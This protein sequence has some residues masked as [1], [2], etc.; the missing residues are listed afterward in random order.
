MSSISQRSLDFVHLF[1]PSACQHAWKLAR[2]STEGEAESLLCHPST[3]CVASELFP[4]SKSS[5]PPAGE[6]L[7]PPS[8]CRSESQALRDGK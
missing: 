1:I 8:L 2:T 3:P 5:R 7:L 6:V 4:D